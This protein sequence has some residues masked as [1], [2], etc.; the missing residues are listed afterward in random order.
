MQVTGGFYRGESAV[1]FT[2]AHRLRVAIPVILF[3]GIA[4]AGGADYVGKAGVGVEF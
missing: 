1:G 4:A 2:A 3:G